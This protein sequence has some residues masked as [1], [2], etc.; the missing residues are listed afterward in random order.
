M[1]KIAPNQFSC[2]SSTMGLCF[3]TLLIVML[4]VQLVSCP[5]FALWS[6]SNIQVLFMFYFMLLIQ[7]QRTQ[8]NGK[9]LEDGNNVHP[10]A[11]MNG[12]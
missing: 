11:Q 6:T 12:T 4:C 2:A 5:S 1:T 8:V 10:D 9:I 7:R 3:V